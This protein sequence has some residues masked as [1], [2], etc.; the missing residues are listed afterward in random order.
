M[1]KFPKETKKFRFKA[2][3]NC[4][5][6]APIPLEI[7]K[8][9]SLPPLIVSKKGSRRKTLDRCVKKLIDRGL[10]NQANLPKESKPERLASPKMYYWKNWPLNSVNALQMGHDAANTND[11]HQQQQQKPEQEHKYRELRF[12]IVWHRDIVAARC[13]M[14]KALCFI[15]DLTLIN[16]FVRPPQLRRPP[17]SK[18]PPVRR[19]PRENANVVPVQV[20]NND[21]PAG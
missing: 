21:Q 18:K 1:V 9:M 10:V 20:N 17:Y 4:P 16:S 3:K 12:T 14:Y 5:R 6:N 13:I 7:A 2:C 19:Q 8:Y 11:H 15:F